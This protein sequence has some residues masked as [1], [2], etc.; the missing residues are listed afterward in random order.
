[1][2]Q[3]CEQLPL[4]M[5]RPQAIDISMRSVTDDGMLKFDNNEKTSTN[6]NNTNDVECPQVLETHPLRPLSS[7]TPNANRRPDE[8]C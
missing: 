7:S 1:M 3:I 6:T 2:L 4:D 5:A 8:R